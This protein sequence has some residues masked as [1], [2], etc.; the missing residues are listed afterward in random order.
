MMDVRTTPFDAAKYLT[1]PADHAELLSDAL[2]TEHGPY[3]AAA[4]GVVARSRGLSR[5]AADTGLS[6]QALH[7]ALSEEGNPTLA[8][9][10]KVLHALGLHLEAK[11]KPL[12]I[13]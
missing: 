12:E 4:L 11:P 13:V 3:I 9:V 5:L 7:R 10:L 8:T 2:E 1:S 6:R